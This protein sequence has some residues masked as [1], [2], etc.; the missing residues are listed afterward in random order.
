[1]QGFIVMTPGIVTPLA[2]DACDN[3]VH[4][5]NPSQADTDGDGAGDACDT[6]LHLYNPSQV[7]SDGNGVGDACEP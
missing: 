2:G 1:M 5:A 3:C 7:D 6:C 4:V